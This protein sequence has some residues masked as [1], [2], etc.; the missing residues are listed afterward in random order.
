VDNSQEIRLRR[1]PPIRHP[2]TVTAFVPGLDLARAFYHDVVNPILNEETEEHANH[3]AALLGTGSEVLGFDTHR[4]T[5]HD[6]GPRLQL[7]VDHPQG[8]DQKLTARLPP[9]YHGYPT[10][11]TNTHEPDQPPRH[12]IEVTDF[13]SWVSALLGFNPLDGVTRTD[14]L[15]T[16]TQ[17]LAEFTAGAVFHDGLNVLGPARTALAWYPDDVWHY[18]LACQWHRIAQE[19]AFPGRCAETGDELGSAVVAA[20]LIRDLMRLCLLMHRR[21]PPYSKWL[22]TAFARLP[23]QGDLPDHLRQAL[24][25]SDWKS[26]EQHLKKAYENVAAQHNQLKITEPLD[27]NTRPYFDRPYQVIDADRFARALLPDNNRPLTGAVDQ[28]VDSTDALGDT[29]LLRRTIS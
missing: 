19:E 9:T 3:S 21:Y 5:D 4:S 6:W 18:V 11:F 7:F 20:R 27:T 2:A 13:N 22:G 23:G 10:A 15:A 25:A 14:W 28:F 16:P 1:V 12:R 29:H 8:L 26:R 24:S 17:R